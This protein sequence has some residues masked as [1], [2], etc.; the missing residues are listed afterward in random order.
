[1]IGHLYTLLL[2]GG[3]EAPAIPK[4]GKGRTLAEI[5]AEWAKTREETQPKK[6]ARKA[7]TKIVREVYFA[8]RDEVA[9]AYVDRL[10]QEREAAQLAEMRALL[11]LQAETGRVS[12]EIARAALELARQQARET[13]RRLEEFDVIYVAAMLAEA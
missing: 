5:E 10:K 13:Q 4:A 3:S 8:P 7:R 6:A 12:A 1:M 2:V 9:T 11:D